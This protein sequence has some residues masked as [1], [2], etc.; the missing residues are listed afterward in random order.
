MVG[1]IYHQQGLFPYSGNPK[2]IKWGVNNGHIFN[3]AG[4]DYLTISNSS[5][6]FLRLQ[7]FHEGFWMEQPFRTYHRN[8]RCQ[9]YFSEPY[10]KIFSRR[11]SDIA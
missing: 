1:I 5:P 3:R 2:A 7:C 4:I 9:S 8:G 6:L 11:E 10:P